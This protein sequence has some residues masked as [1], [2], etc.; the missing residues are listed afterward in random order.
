MGDSG[1]QPDVPEGFSRLGWTDSTGR[2]VYFSAGDVDTDRDSLAESL[3][4]A[5]RGKNTETSIEEGLYQQEVEEEDPL[6]CRGKS[7]IQPE[8]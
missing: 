7:R 3:A 1:S 8:V 2:R 6:F 4:R 5:L